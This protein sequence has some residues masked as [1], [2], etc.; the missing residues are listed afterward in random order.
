M[1]SGLSQPT[2]RSTR[3]QGRASAASSQP[4]GGPLALESSVC[5][6]SGGPPEL[7]SPGAGPPL[8][9]KGFFLGSSQALGPG[10]NTHRN[11]KHATTWPGERVGG[12]GELGPGAVGSRLSPRT[13]RS[14]STALVR[15]RLGSRSRLS[16]PAPFSPCG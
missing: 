1:D 4:D 2:S 12:R 6:K 15:P 14:V 8:S 11:K 13:T 16:L 3:S 7:L 5:W 9:L 10:E